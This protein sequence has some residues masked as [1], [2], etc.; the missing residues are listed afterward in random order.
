MKV[1][2]VIS[3]SG[4]SSGGSIQALLL[5]R[6][7]ADRG[8]DS[9]FVSKGGDCALKAR[10]MGVKSLSVSM[11]W[12]P[13]GVLEFVKAL[14]RFDVLHAH[15]GK[16]LS[17]CLL[18]VLITGKGRVFANRGVSFPLSWSNRWKYAI[19]LTRGVICVSFGV[20]RLLMGEGIRGEKL[21]VV[22]GSLDERFFN[23]RPKPLCLKELGLGNAF[24]V[25][26]VGN[27]R[28]WKGH[29]ILARALSS[30]RRSIPGAV[31]LL[32]GK[33]KR[34]ILE[35]VEE[36]LGGA[37]VSLGYR[38]DVERVM[39]AMDVLVNASTEGEGVPG[40]IREAMALGIPVVASSLDGNR[41]MVRHGKNGLLF[42]VGDADALSRLISLLL[43]TPA[44]GKRLGVGG[45][46][47]ARRFTGAERARRMLRIYEGG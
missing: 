47:F 32:A 40:V 11:S 37:F 35:K 25:G 43:L 27:F 21:Y 5:A 10:R 4:C 45:R 20:K 13:R 42:P 14:K 34:G 12:S 33:E 31:M 46:R 15:K 17:F 26:L 28:P 3:R 24:Y 38:E 39:G 8:V 6:S 1:A 30:V 41:E 22:Y 36:L 23:P 19:P 2:Q 18:H 7:L 9:L 44:L 29:L 16:A